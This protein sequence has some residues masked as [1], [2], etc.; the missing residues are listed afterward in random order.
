MK[1]K[2]LLAPYVNVGIIN[3]VL[4][5]GF[6]SIQKKIKNKKLQ[7]IILNVA[8]YWKTPR[9]ID[10]V[11][12]FL[13]SLDLNGTDYSPMQIIEIFK[14][15][16]YLIDSSCY[17]PDNRYSRH[18]LYYNLSGASA[19]GLQDIL[20][21]KKVII[22]G[23]GG[24]GNIISLSLAT[25]GVG[26]LIL[27]DSDIIEISNLTRQIMFEEKDTGK[28]KIEILKKA[29]LKR[30]SEIKVSTMDL[31]I[32]SFEDL[33]SLPN[34]DLII[35]SADKPNSLI[36]WV[37][38]Y[39][40]KNNIPYINVGYVMDIAVWGP[41]VIPGETG[42]WDCRPLIAQNESYEN[43]VTN[44]I[45]AINKNNQVPS[46][47]PINMMAASHALIDVLKYLGGFGTI[48][49]L[50]KR[51]GIWTHNLTIEYQDCSKNKECKTCSHL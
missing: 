2:Y 28:K 5:F 44:L 47:G 20:A 16:N 8:A 24:I 18:F 43:E 50:N 37:N 4:H 3:D 27:I 39:S 14:D 36:T 17:N 31:I 51:I 6:G 11:L 26:E 48:A 42:C 9:K 49:S 7:K 34:S 23:C 10:E 1:N 46:I 15:G 38:N 25:A 22:L 40:V 45:K 35:L 12:N 30:N 41:F 29:L 33:F 32:N 21:S 19:S 13:T